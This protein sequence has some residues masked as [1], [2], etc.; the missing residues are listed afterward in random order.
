M[1]IILVALS[2]VVGIL[3]ILQGWQMTQSRRE[4]RNP[5]SVAHK[6][7]IVISKLELLSRRIDDIWDRVKGE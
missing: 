6:L 4:R 3:A 5:N 1:E 2:I 7:D